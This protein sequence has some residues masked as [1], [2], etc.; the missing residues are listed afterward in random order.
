[1]LA[2]DHPLAGLQAQAALATGWPTLHVFRADE[3]V[4]LRARQVVE[5]LLGPLPQADVIEPW[6]PRDPT[7]PWELRI[8][9]PG[10]HP[11]VWATLRAALSELPGP[12]PVLVPGLR[13]GERDVV[14][15]GWWHFEDVAA[16]GIVARA[17]LAGGE[18]VAPDL[19]VGDGDEAVRALEQQLAVALQEA[20]VRAPFES[21]RGPD[22]LAPVVHRDSGRFGVQARFAPSVFE[23]LSGDE[24]RALREQIIEVVAGLVRTRAEHPVL[25]L[26]PDPLWDARWGFALTLWIVGPAAPG[27]PGDAPL[28]PGVTPFPATVD[29]WAARLDGQVE[30][31]EVQVVPETPG[32]HDAMVAAV[33][34]KIVEAD[35]PLL[36]GRPR[37]LLRAG[38]EEAEPVFTPTWRWLG[39]RRSLAS[40]LADLADL[41]GVEAV[42]VVPGEPAGLGEAW[43]QARPAWHVGAARWVQRVR[44]A[45]TDRDRLPQVT[46]R[47]PERRDGEAIAALL[48]LLER[49]GGAMPA[50]PPRLVADT[51]GRPGIELRLDGRALSEP[52]LRR[53]LDAVAAVEHPELV[54]VAHWGYLQSTP[55][56]YL[57]FEAP[58]T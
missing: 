20:G 44:D 2:A 27:L 53:A 45:L 54:P 22:T 50:Q 15:Q 24:A 46:E 39:W 42:R 43:Q 31:L 38:S 8:D 12:A 23:T 4:V 1:M 28:D 48:P 29:A 6:D 7:E 10:L 3:A 13:D 34:V 36:G 11:A 55:L 30:D 40:I 21:D 25:R 51:S 33:M 47:A 41:P 49:G 14:D 17:R 32:E 37:W 5:D 16:G 9:L 56:V 57:W 35:W 19:H 52:G 18:P 26:A 58:D